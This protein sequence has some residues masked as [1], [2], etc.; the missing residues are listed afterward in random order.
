MDF[1][2]FNFFFLSYLLFLYKYNHTHTLMLSTEPSPTAYRQTDTLLRL[3]VGM[4]LALCQL[5]R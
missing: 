1:S 3:T 2:A 5:L 4:P